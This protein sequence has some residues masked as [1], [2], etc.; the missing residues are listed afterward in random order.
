[1]KHYYRTT[2]ECEFVEFIN[3]YFFLR[4][5]TLCIIKSMYS[6]LSYNLVTSTDKT[7]IC[8]TLK[9]LQ[10]S[11]IAKKKVGQRLKSPLVSKAA[12]KSEN[13]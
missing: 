7:I 2:Q 1:M 6:N 11:G 4:L 13:S 8:F 9:Y 10:V 5:V 3:S 12:P